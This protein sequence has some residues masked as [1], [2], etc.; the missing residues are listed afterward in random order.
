[1][2]QRI[3]GELAAAWSP[4]ADEA[5]AAAW[6]LDADEAMA[7]AWSFDEGEALAMAWSFGADEALA[8]AW[9]PGVDEG[10]AVTPPGCDTPA[11]CPEGLVVFQGRVVASHHDP[12]RQENQTSRQDEAAVEN[13][14]GRW[15][16]C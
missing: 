14:G 2:D 16:A 9:N 1:M 13:G 4:G 5:T 12:T 15:E 8:A 3:H 7:T 10:A 11:A 6:S